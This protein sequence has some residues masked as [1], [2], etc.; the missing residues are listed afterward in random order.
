MKLKAKIKAIYKL[1]NRPSRG[2]QVV[3]DSGP[4]CPALDFIVSA[5]LDCS[6]SPQQSRRFHLDCLH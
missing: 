3:W 5:A 4:F 6:S 2:M 1:Q